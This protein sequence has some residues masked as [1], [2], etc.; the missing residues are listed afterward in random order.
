MLEHFC[1][2][3]IEVGGA[4]KHASLNAEMYQTEQVKEAISHVYAHIILFFQQAVKWYSMSSI[5]RVLSA[6][7]NPPELDYAKT[8]QQIKFWAESIK[9][10]ASAAGRAELRDVHVTVQS[11]HRKL[12]EMQ[13][14]M[15]KWQ[16]EMDEKVSRVI[17]IGT[18]KV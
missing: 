13:D 6:V 12:L 8:V 5:R 15:K 16:R 4:L 9:D 14:H 3:M 10:I 18:S 1:Q 7:A 17:Q 2:A 11:Q